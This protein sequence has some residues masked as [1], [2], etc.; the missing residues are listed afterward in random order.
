MTEP[1][2]LKLRIDAPVDDVWHALTDAD[3]LRAWFAEDVRVQLPDTYE[4]WG[5]YTPDGAEPRQRLL[6]AADG[7]LRYAWRIDGTDTTVEI[8]LAPET[9][10]ST[11]LTLTQTNLPGFA[12]MVYGDS[13]LGEIHTFWTLALVN[14]ADHV[15]GRALTGR[16]DYTAT[17]LRA[18]VTIDAD[19]HAVYQSLTDPAV[20]GKWF[21]ANVSA[22]PEVGGRFAMGPLDSDAPTAHY[23]R[24][25]AD[26]AAALEWP[27]GMVE[28]WELADSDGATRLT[29]VQS[30]FDDAHRGY[31]G[32]AGALAGLSEL[33]R[34]HEIPDWRRMWL[35][36]YVPGMPEGILAV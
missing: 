12:E 26:A 16:C 29:Y 24:L 20:F 15:T 2:K 17:D 23:V 3:A 25:D 13:V 35:A 36:V 14:L 27:D 22:E 10:K 9:D 18:E 1:T 32:W 30:G 19:R 6:H 34:F 7:T 33:R 21:G 5:R 28:T 8:R 31:A 4:F 11:V